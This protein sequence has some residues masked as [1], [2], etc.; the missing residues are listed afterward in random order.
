MSKRFSYAGLSSL[1]FGCVSHVFQTV[2][3]GRKN[4]AWNASHMASESLLSFRKVVL[5]SFILLFFPISSHAALLEM[6]IIEG[7][8]GGGILFSQPE[9]AGRGFCEAFNNGMT[10]SHVELRDPGDSQLRPVYKV[11]CWPPGNENPVSDQAGTIWNIKWMRTCE[12]N[13]FGISPISAKHPQSTEGKCVGAQDSLQIANSGNFCPI[14]G[15][16]IQLSSG[17]KSQQGVDYRG[18]GAFPLKFSRG[19]P[20]NCVTGLS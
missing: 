6:P 14:D 18:T 16:P 13:G 19:C 17:N 8:H 7:Y 12:T 9:E 1:L 2:L 5:L 4:G 11:W 15:N 10:F 20:N 3:F